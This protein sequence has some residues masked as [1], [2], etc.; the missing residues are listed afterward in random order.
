MAKNAESG[1]LRPS[2]FRHSR[3]SKDTMSKA[4][5]YDS[6]GDIL[7]TKV[8][9]PNSL[10]HLHPTRFGPRPKTAW[11]RYTRP[12]TAGSSRPQSRASRPQSAPLGGR[13]STVGSMA[14]TNFS[15]TTKKSMVD[16]MIDG[17]RG[18]PMVGV[19]TYPY[20]RAQKQY[21][22]DF[23]SLVATSID[24]PYMATTGFNVA[25]VPHHLL[26]GSAYDDDRMARMAGFTGKWRSEY[27]LSYPVK[28]YVEA[29]NVL[30]TGVRS[31]QV[32][33]LG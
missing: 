18:P 10:E 31:E 30:P 3:S 21:L 20:T 24:H 12:S 19:T 29:K 1:W 25:S 23:R 17:D 5:L 16:E 26:R 8:H 28:S 32:Q 14:S 6:H 27:K 7:V 13:P 11:N 2:G 33:F 4:S 9:K 15:G 22:S